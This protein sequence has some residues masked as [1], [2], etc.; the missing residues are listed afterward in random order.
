ML[1]RLVALVFHH[2]GLRGA[3]R[4]ARGGVP[5]VMFHNVGHAEE[6][7]YLPGHMK[8]STERLRRLL[9]LLQRARYRFL[10]VGQMLTAL[11]AGEVPHDAVVLTFDDG[12]RDNFEV[13]LPLLKEFDATATIFVQTGPMKGKL[14]WLH[15]YF[16][17]LHQRGPHALGAMLAEHVS[18]Q[19]TKA[20][21]LALPAGDVAGEYE[22]KRLLKY[23]VLPE[24]RDEILRRIFDEAGGDER[25]LAEEVYLSPDDCR[26]LDAAGIELGA[27][28]VNHLV[29][30]SLD[31]NQQRREIEGSLRD[32]QSWLG[33][34]VPTFAY[35]YGRLWD[36]DE[37]TLQILEDLGFESAITAMPGVNDAE[38]PRF[39]LKRFAMNDDS[40][41]GEV[42][43]DVDG[44][45][46]WLERR[47]LR[48][49]V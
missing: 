48:L 38:T 15:H 35:P 18:R 16:W 41:M 9:Q 21:L 27:H 4:R 22:L 39:E 14:N 23:D 28:T 11:K 17:V 24:E 29:L 1:R 5:V 6:T 32:L 46:T 40:N 25:K 3:F 8:T 31:E 20:D 44:V 34:E 7:A 36:Y 43:C 10:T 30:S 26:A 47:G 42:M 19:H 33:H 49:T 37:H 45:Y 2:L 12:Y 13:L